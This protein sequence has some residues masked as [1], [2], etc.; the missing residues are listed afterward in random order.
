M[1]W[2]LMAFRIVALIVN[3]LFLF[4]RKKNMIQIACCR[5]VQS[6]LRQYGVSFYKQQKFYYYIDEV[7]VV[8]CPL[9]P[10]FKDR[11]MNANI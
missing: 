5:F 8:P 3:R 9:H 1:F 4:E 2:V 6:K 11:F 10:Q 7:Y